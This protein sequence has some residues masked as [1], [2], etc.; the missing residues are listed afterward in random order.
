V[1][2][3]L[4][5]DRWL[6][7]TTF[8]KWLQLIGRLHHSLICDNQSQIILYSRTQWKRYGQF[9]PLIHH[10]FF[11]YFNDWLIEK[12]RKRLKNDFWM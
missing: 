8:F 1:A 11:K 2:G 5:S 3:E 9:N 7:N 12:N 4:L 6:L 10:S